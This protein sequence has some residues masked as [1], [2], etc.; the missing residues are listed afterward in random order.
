[1]HTGHTHF[2]IMSSVSEIEQEIKEVK[3]EIFSEK[4]AL[5]GRRRDLKEDEDALAIAR[6][7]CDVV[8]QDNFNHAIVCSETDIKHREHKL[9]ILQDRLTSLELQQLAVAPQSFPPSPHQ[10]SAAAAPQQ[11]YDAK[12]PG[13]PHPPRSGGMAAGGRAG[14]AAL[15]KLKL[16]KKK[17]PGLQATPVSSKQYPLFKN[18]AKTIHDKNDDEKLSLC[19]FECS[20]SYDD[21]ALDILTWLGCLDPPLPEVRHNLPRANPSF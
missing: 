15:P 3:L 5:Q 16:E 17:Q 20:H 10:P 13:T 12:P 1:M 9:S 4:R 18:M 19:T 8:S 6:S 11:E 21:K 7:I 2:I 14:A